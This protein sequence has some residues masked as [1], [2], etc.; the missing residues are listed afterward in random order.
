MRDLRKPLIRILVVSQT[1]GVAELAAVVDLD[2]REC[3]ISLTQ[4]GDA[5]E[6]LRDAA[7][8]RV[9]NDVASQRLNRRWF[10]LAVHR[11]TFRCLSD[12]R[13][14]ERRRAESSQRH[15]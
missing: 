4:F 1:D 11:A 12:K 7:M 14:P 5:R 9:I 15:P 10:S 8:T 2:V 3:G 13:I 6:T